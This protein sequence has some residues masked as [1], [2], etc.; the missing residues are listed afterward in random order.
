MRKIFKNRAV[1]HLLLVVALVMGLFVGVMAVSAQSELT[2]LTLADEVFM[3]NCG[4]R[5]YED[6]GGRVATAETIHFMAVYVLAQDTDWPSLLMSGDW[7]SNTSGRAAVLVMGWTDK[8]GPYTDK[9]SWKAHNCSACTVAPDYFWVCW[10][11]V[12]DYSRG[13]FSLS[14]PYINL[15]GVGLGIDWDEETVES[16]GEIS[17]R[18]RVALRGTV[19]ATEIRYYKP[20]TMLSMVNVDGDE[21]AEPAWNAYSSSPKLYWIED[22]ATCMASLLG[23]YAFI[24]DWLYAHF[25]VLLCPDEEPN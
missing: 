4:L 18:G 15:N 9:A 11:D 8:Y 5:F 3:G 16:F 17:M 19:E 7:A 6:D 10:G 1:V 2:Y 13:W 14:K 25:G 12:G 23:D 24:C 21:L 20:S 22:G